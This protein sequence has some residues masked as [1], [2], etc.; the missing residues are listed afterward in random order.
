MA[1]AS[2][3]T[4]GYLHLPNMMQPGL[5]EFARD[6]YPQHYKQALINDDRYN[7]GGFVGDM[8]IDRLEREIWAI[9][10]PREGKIVRN[11]ERV[12]HGHLAVLINEDT[13]SNGEYFAEAIKQKKL[14]TLIGMRTWGGAVGIEPHQRMMDG[15]TVT[16]PQFAPYGMKGEW[17]IEGHGVEPDVQ[18][19]NLPQ[20]VLHGRDDQLDAAV[21]L[22]LR[23]IAEEPMTLPNPPAF[24]DKSK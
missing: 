4:I 24:P 10:L 8:I 9:T 2:D 23:R 14:A 15:G 17:L 3:G 22:L 1:S 21:E 18:I 19:Q 20:D 16:P 5:I 7:G 12:F 13:G 11:P 6:F